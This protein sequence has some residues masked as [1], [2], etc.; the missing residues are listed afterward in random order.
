[1]LLKEQLDNDIKEA[2]K[3][4]NETALS[5]LRMLR[6]AV[7]NKAIELKKKDE[8]LNEEET[9]AI[10]KSEVK[11]LKDAIVDFEKG[12][13]ADLVEQNKKEIEI[14]QKY[15]PEEMA[16]EEVREVVKKV[17]EEMGATQ[18]D[19]GKVMGRVMGELKGKADGGLVR[20]VAQEE[21]SA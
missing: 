13:R 8:G 10:I 19:M 12:K 15:L 17:I 20:K 2:M 14:L 4:R 21:L 18:S 16:E 3:S 5:T 11:K 7:M 9:L 1:M 6:A